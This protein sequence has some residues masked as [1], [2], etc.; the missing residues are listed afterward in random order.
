[1]KKQSL[2]DFA[3]CLIFILGSSKEEFDNRIIEKV[4][5]NSSLLQRVSVPGCWGVYPWKAD[6]QIRSFIFVLSLIFSF[7]EL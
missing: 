7:P 3:C 4:F 6:I 1:M 5:S 2:I